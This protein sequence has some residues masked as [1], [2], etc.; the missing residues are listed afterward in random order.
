MS[1]LTVLDLFSGCGGMS[2]GFQ[3]AGFE[4]L[5]GV[6][7]DH[8]AAMTYTKNLFKG[9]TPEEMEK[10]LEARDINTYMPRDFARDFL[11]TDQLKDQVDIL[12]GGPPCQAFA[13]IGRAKLRQIMDHKEC[14]LTHL[15]RKLL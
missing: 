10:H 3:R 12:I 13:R 9:S 4:I 11:N 5:G 1:S 7:F 8:N 6:E 2:L 14:M 15:N